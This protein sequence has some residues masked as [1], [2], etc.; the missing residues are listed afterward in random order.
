M[1]QRLLRAIIR[2]LSRAV[3]TDPVMYDIYLETVSSVVQETYRKHF[4]DLPID[5]KVTEFSRDCAVTL[6]NTLEV[7]GTKEGGR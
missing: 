1:L 5:D 3:K 4:P 6:L 7:I 2:S